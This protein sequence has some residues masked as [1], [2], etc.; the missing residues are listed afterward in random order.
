MSVFDSLVGQEAAVDVLKAA[1]AAGR[2]LAKGQEPPTSSAMSHAW[3]FTGPPGSGRSLAARTLAAALLCTGPEPGCGQCPGC[4]AAMADNHP[5]LTTVS[6]DLVTISADEVREYVASAFVAPSQGHY[7]IFLIEDADRMVERTT[8]VLLKAIEE[9]GEHTVWMLCTAAP[10]DVLPTIRSRCR[11]VN[12]VTPSAQEVADLLVE[13]DGIE[14]K[15]AMLAARAS[16]S[17]VGVARALALNED[18]AAAIRRHTLDAIVSIK[19][20]GDAEMAAIR[21]MDPEAMRGEKTPKA[22]TKAAKAAK[23]AQAEAAKRKV[24]EA[25]G[26]DADSKVPTS[27]RGEIKAAL[28]SAKK[29]ATRNQRDLLDREL[30]YAI[31]LYRDVLV[32]QLGS[33][34]ELINQDYIEAIANLAS[35]LTP[36]LVLKKIEKLGEARERLA[37]N[38]APQLAMEAAMMALRLTPHA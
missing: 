18:G 3:L 37:A 24:M 38:V 8:N 11:G 13:R 5:D 14:P 29:R 9:P 12:L 25:Y 17:H 16:Q 27:M 35:E 28:D 4:L 21:L 10:A 15:Q 6:T 34:V 26:L 33:D 23:D 2:A 30:I 19:G 36:A 31:G 7:R 22:G 1:A 32:T 20:V